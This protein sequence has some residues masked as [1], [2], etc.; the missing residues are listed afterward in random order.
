MMVDTLLVHD[1][2]IIDHSILMKIM[3]NL[4]IYFT[5]SLSHR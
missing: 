2:H 4:E 3:Q 1:A 5:E